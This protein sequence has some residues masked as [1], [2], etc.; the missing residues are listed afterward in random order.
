[1]QMVGEIARGAGLS[2]AISMHAWRSLILDD[3]LRK[4]KDDAMER[5]KTEGNPLAWSAVT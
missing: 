2:T 1:M 3:L 4:A 5:E